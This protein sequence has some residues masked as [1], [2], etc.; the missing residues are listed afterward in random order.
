MNRFRGFKIGKF[1]LIKQKTDTSA[2]SVEKWITPEE[3]KTLKSVEGIDIVRD[4]NGQAVMKRAVGIHY[5]DVN[6]TEFHTYWIDIT[7]IDPYKE[8]E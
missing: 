4:E 8:E 1:L 5:K 2:S 7:R 6:E 3:W